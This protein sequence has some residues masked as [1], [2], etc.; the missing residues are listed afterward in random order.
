MTGSAAGSTNGSAPLT[1]TVAIVGGGPVGL[2]TALLLDRQGLDVVV[3]ERRT[4]VQPAPAA[5]VVNARTFEIC[6]AAGV[7]GDALAAACQPAEDGAWVRWVTT[8]TGDELG[9]VPFERQGELAALDHV[10]P[11]PLRNLS[12]H[13][14]EPIL[15]AEVARRPGITLLTGVEWRGA[16]DGGDRVVSRVADAAAGNGSGGAGLGGG[17]ASRVADLGAGGT[18]ASSDER[19]VVSSWLIGADGAGSPVRRWCGIAMDGPTR[20]TS[21]VSIHVEADLRRLVADRPATLYWTTDPDH[22][23]VFVAHDLGR[24][25]V[26]MHPWDPDAESLDDYPPERCA[27]IFCA[28]AGLDVDD[29]LDSQIDLVV[30][31]VTPWTMTCQVAERYRHG[32][33]LLVGDAAHRFPPTGGLGLNTGAADGFDLAWKL[34]AVEAGWAHPD[35]L[36]T[37]EAE[38]RPIA[39]ANAEQSLTNAVKLLDVEAALGGHPDPAERRRRYDDVLASAEDRSRLVAAIE[40]Q[41]EHFDMLGLQLGFAYADSPGVVVASSDPPDDPSAPTAPLTQEVDPVRH[42]VPTTR[43]GGRLPHAWVQTADGTRVSTLDLVPAT[44][45]LLLTASPAWA[46]AAGSLLAADSL[47]ADDGA[48]RDELG[49]V[50]QVGEVGEVADGASDRPRPGAAATIDGRPPLTVV[51]VGRDVEDVTGHWTK[52][53]GLGDAGAVLVRPDQHVLW[54]S[55]DEA[56]PDAADQLAAALATMAGRTVATPAV[57]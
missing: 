52:V 20:L 53:A 10:T 1:A 15:R 44:G 50:S 27:A 29:D 21:I 40:A 17:S 13:R 43:P 49:E 7:D 23:G 55:L 57:A 54:R 25:W 32:R 51:L 38:R 14:L 19:E 9:A 31:T 56:G 12:Q 45:A 26:Y 2:L 16:T 33:V 41:A 35:L 47:L 11:S 6:R 36:D 30:R 5:H 8:L 37:Y 48:N 34:G 42:Y 28:A 3:L 22:A 24:T 46:E 39:V 4:D 18:P